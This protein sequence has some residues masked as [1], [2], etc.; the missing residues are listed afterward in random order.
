M[1]WELCDHSGAGHPDLPTRRRG[2][3]LVEVVVVIGI[4]G[5]LMAI[6]FPA[7]QS[8]RGRVRQSQCSNNLRQI[9]LALSHYTSQFGRFPFGVG[10][11]SGSVTYTSAANRRYSTHSQLLPFLEQQSLY[12]Q[13]DFTVRPF[14]PDLSG[15]PD[16]VTGMGPNEPVAQTR[17]P[18]FLCPSDGNRLG[19]P[20]APN[21]YRSCSGSDWDPRQGNG[22]FSQRVMRRP[23]EA[24]DG[25]SHVAAFSERII[26][27]GTDAEV[28][29][30]SDLFADGEEWTEDELTRWCADLTADRAEELPVQDSNGGMTWLEGNMN[31]TRYNHVLA[32]G[33][34]SC[35]NRITWAGTIMSASSRHPGG[36][37]V[38]L[39]GGAVR[40][41]GEEVDLET[42]RALGNRNSG[43]VIDAEEW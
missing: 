4:I 3:T 13:I 16:R 31:W 43:Q 20:W 34:P 8:V 2:M 39:A 14:Y 36:V 23:A 17:V 6:L 5:I 12:E 7:V 38:L 22:L 42:W 41:V 32:P 27:D 9:G 35:K 11:D 29:M 25:L 15:D 10:V 21:S 37:Q 26:G 1:A 33:Q 28:E 30:V 19:R 24:L 18:V 40:L